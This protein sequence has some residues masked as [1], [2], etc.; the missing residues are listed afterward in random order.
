MARKDVVKFVCDACGR[1]EEDEMCCEEP[2]H[3]YPKGWSSVP[4]TLA[5]GTSD[6]GNKWHDVCPNCRGNWNALLIN[7][8]ANE[9]LNGTEEDK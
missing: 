2:M 6:C 5:N 1:V 7:F 8:F 4:A 3:G 9:D